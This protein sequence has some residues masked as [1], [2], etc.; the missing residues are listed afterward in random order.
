[1]ELPMQL[2]VYVAAAILFVQ[3]ALVCA[4]RNLPSH[5]RHFGFLTMALTVSVLLV[6]ML[7]LNGQFVFAREFGYLLAGGKHADVWLGFLLL[8]IALL[9]GFGWRIARVE[10]G[11]TS[12][13]RWYLGA[14]LI[15]GALSIAGI[16]RI[17]GEGDLPIVSLHYYDVWWPP[18]ALWLSACL[19]GA[20][21]SVL[22]WESRVTLRSWSIEIGRLCCISSGSAIL[23]LAAVHARSGA[24]K[25][26]VMFW[27]VV[28]FVSSP[29]AM[30]TAARAA[31]QSLSW[32]GLLAY[33]ALG[34][35]PAAIAAVS[36]AKALPAALG[37]WIVGMIVALWPA[38]GPLLRFCWR[39]DP[40]AS[41]ADVHSTKPPLI[42]FLILVIG[43]SLISSVLGLGNVSIAITL[44]FFFVA[45]AALSDVVSEDGVFERSW[46]LIREPSSLGHWFAAAV[47]VVWNGLGGLLQQIAKALSADKW[48]GAAFKIF[49]AVVLL[50]ALAELPNAGRTIV[51]PFEV[52]G[53][54]GD[55]KLSK[56]LG[57]QLSNHVVHELKTLVRELSREVAYTSVDRSPGSKTSVYEHE[58]SG[59]GELLAKSGSIELPGGLKLP[60]E[61]LVSPIQTPARWLFNV[62]IINGSVVKNGDGYAVTAASSRG[63]AWRVVHPS[64]QRGETP[65]NGDACGRE[66]NAVDAAAPTAAAAVEPIAKR[67]AFDIL[68]D[69]QETRFARV[70]RDWD[71]YLAYSEGLAAFDKHVAAGFYDQKNLN[72]AIACLRKAA[73]LDPTS[74]LTHYR[75]GLA[76]QQDGQVFPANDAFQRSLDLDP[77]FVAAKVALGVL[78]SSD[79]LITTSLPPGAVEHKLSERDARAD[80]LW[81][82]VVEEP[83]ASLHDVAT[84]YDR[85]ANLGLQSLNGATWGDPAAK[86]AALFAYYNA[87]R[88][89]GSYR[90]LRF[91][92]KANV[93]II[94]GYASAIDLLG[95]VLD[96][97]ARETTS[98]PP[99]DWSCDQGAPMEPIETLEVGPYARD[100]LDYYDEA[101]EELPSDPVIR[102]NAA[103]SALALGDATA[104]RQ[105]QSV[106]DVRRETGDKIAPNDLATLNQKLAEYSEAAS[107]N[108]ADTTA[109]NAY[110]YAYYSYRRTN[111]EVGDDAVALLSLGL[112][113]EESAKEAVRIAK[114]AGQEDL[115]LYESTLGEVLLAMHR[116]DEAAEIFEGIFA[117]QGVPDHPRFSEVKWDLAQ[118]YSCIA[119]EKGHDGAY[120]TKAQ[121]ILNGIRERD[122]RMS[123]PLFDKTA[124]E[125]DVLI[126]QGLCK[127]GPEYSLTGDKGVDIAF[128]VKE[129]TSTRIEPCDRNVLRVWAPEEADNLAVLAW[130][131]D[132]FFFD[133]VPKPGPVYR[134]LSWTPIES[135]GKYF[136]RLY[137]KLE[138]ENDYKPVSTVRVIDTSKDC[139]RNA[140]DISYQRTSPRD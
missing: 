72:D 91:E 138:S 120:L 44:A 13:L 20:L 79:T 119:E 73:R 28:L 103:L 122:Q 43:L 78:R 116:Y 75:L 23:A 99:I 89:I 139:E 64:P 1:M 86:A 37:A 113:A 110:A 46:R 114:V 84:A 62:D 108:R 81:A 22:R 9:A 42:A 130:G 40:S 117:R 97:V 121:S 19:V 33:A 31:R 54:I 10:A 21:L 53:E 39:I 132:Q 125:L 100:A 71:A 32:G 24:F 77:R 70:T 41:S 58:Q 74:P 93:S 16:E 131:G 66:Q 118:A 34:L 85:L 5:V 36:P 56:Q 98:I 82:A 59:S 124:G 104:M 55:E 50:V 107:I 63:D 4:K 135:H 140:V 68:F 26:S 2:L 109:L 92:T 96:S 127:Q 3:G 51:M 35:V 134:V 90:K 133:V 6:Y 76:L 95:V 106:A 30:V 7:S 80:S 88:A 48:Y 128:E 87:R 111:P 105:L 137:A 8:G 60:V 57:E 61:L 123:V 45:W 14:G 11:K 47:R 17:G 129:E 83:S 52:S 38:R 94:Q 126:T 69:G 29:L 12:R 65:N 25:D 115:W 136:V 101:L 112:L 18:L 15:V 102:C 49:L 27:Y 67:L